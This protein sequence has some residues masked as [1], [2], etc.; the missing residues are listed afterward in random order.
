MILTNTQERAR[1]IKFAIV[2][3]IG[4][5][6]D[7][8]IFN[9]L[10]GLFNIPAIIAQVFSFLAAVT[11]NFLW[12]RYWTYPDS[13]SKPL[14]HQ[15]VQFLIVNIIG[16]AIRTPLFTGLEALL[17]HEWEI[18]SPNF[19]SPVFVGHNIAL[20]VAVIVV[21]LWNFFIN[22]YWTYNDVKLSD[23]KA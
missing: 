6:V 3:T 16:L 8:G 22:R 18:L 2:G 4:A 7:F 17:I 14:Q 11:S 1:F 13:R 10:S 9:L 5:V 19:L 15:V 12:N 23:S 20:A 21:M